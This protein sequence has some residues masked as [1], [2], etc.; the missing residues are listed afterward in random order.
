MKKLWVI[1]FKTAKSIYDEY[2][3]QIAA[4]YNTWNEFEHGEHPKAD[5]AGILRLDKETGMPEFTD[6]TE[7]IEK[8]WLAFWSLRDYYRLN[9]E[10][11]KEIKKG[12][13]VNG[14]MAPSV[15]EILN[16]LA[17]QALIPWAVNSTVDYFQDNLKDL[18]NPELSV[19]NIEYIFKKAKT[20]YRTISKKAMDTGSLVHDAIECYLSGGK[21]EPI[22]EGNDGATNSFLAFLEWK[23]K[24]RLEPIFLEK[25]LIDPNLEFGGTV[26]L[27]TW[28]EIPE[29]EET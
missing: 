13:K 16:I 15:T 26:D 11:E 28:A 6:C 29:K 3:L 2:L 7:G 17:K 5:A 27:I 14:H 22:L 25:Q 12:Y 18:R 1:D 24:V 8:K 20:A 4:Y 21:P 9:I 23:E 19:E 10:G